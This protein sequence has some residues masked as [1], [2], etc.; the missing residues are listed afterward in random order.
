M[1]KNDND[2][3]LINYWRYM[4]QNNTNNI[5]E[6]CVAEGIEKPELVVEFDN[7][8]KKSQ[9]M[10]LPHIGALVGAVLGQDI[11][12]LVSNKDQPI[13]NVFCFDGVTNNGVIYKCM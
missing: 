10:E 9:G 13:A 6:W 12:K 3:M 2:K 11:I 4:T 8:Y 5:N 7:I 1:N